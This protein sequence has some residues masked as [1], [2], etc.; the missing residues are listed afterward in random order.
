MVI[1]I[2]PGKIEEVTEALAD[3]TMLVY[4]LVAEE[5]SD[6]WATALVAE[7]DLVGVCPVRFEKRKDAKEWI[8]KRGKVAAITNFDGSIRKLLTR[9]EALEEDSLQDALAEASADT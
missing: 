8:S 9:A 2:P 4:L 3:E 1:Q 7:Q 5:S 6:E